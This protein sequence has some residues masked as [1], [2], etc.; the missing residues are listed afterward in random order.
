MVEQAASNESISAVAGQERLTQSTTGSEK[1]DTA[2]NSQEDQQVNAGNDRQLL[3]FDEDLWDKLDRVAA[4]QKHG[5]SMVL[6][7]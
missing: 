3:T 1:G 5:S 7:L 6:G 2:N 4:Y